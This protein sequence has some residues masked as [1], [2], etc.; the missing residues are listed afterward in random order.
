V[1]TTTSSSNQLRLP[2]TQADSSQ[3]S[4]N[5]PLVEA[6]GLSRRFG[7][8]WAFAHVDLRVMPGERILL[9]GAN[10]SGKTTLLRVLSTLLPPSAGTLRLF[11]KNPTQDSDS[12]RT[13]IELLSHFPGFY[14]DLSAPDNLSVFAGLMGKQANIDGLLSAVALEKRPD[15]VRTFSA[16][17]RKRLQL[18][19]LLLKSPG[20][21]LV[22]EP[23]AALDPSGCALVEGLLRGLPGALLLASHQLERA[24]ALCDRAILLDKGQIRWSGPAGEASR[25]WRMLHGKGPEEISP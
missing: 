17:M 6:Q 16:G 15:P 5:R 4:A 22:D 20:L 10:G 18:A 19:L 12:V 11:G 8:R 1:P 2:L 24:S 14:E 7:Q 23:F 21:A 25:A 13:Q 3:E 9:M